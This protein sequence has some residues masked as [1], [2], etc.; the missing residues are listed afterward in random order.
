MKRP[1]KNKRPLGP[2]IQL[3]KSASGTS[4]DSSFE[5]VEEDNGDAIDDP[6]LQQAE[7]WYEQISKEQNKRKM[8]KNYFKSMTDLPESEIDDKLDRAGL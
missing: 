7:N 5:D 4:A 8:M 2:L 6:I 3:S 1:L